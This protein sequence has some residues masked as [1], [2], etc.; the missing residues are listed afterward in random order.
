MLLAPAA[1]RILEMRL[2]PDIFGAFEHHVL[3]K[4]GK[5]RKPGTLIGRSDVIPEIH[6]DERQTVIFQ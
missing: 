3:E 4:M 2:L 5:S 1:S 6:G